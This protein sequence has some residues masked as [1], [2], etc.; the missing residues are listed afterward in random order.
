M[1]ISPRSRLVTA[2]LLVLVGLAA[3]GVG[4]AFA[5]T[6]G[7]ATP[8]GSGVVVV[9]TNLGYQSAAAAGTGIVLRSSGIVLTNNHVIAGATTVKVVVPQTGQSYKADVLGYDKTADVAL[10]RLHGASNLKTISTGDASDLA[11]GDAVTA[12]GNA[13]GTGHLTSVRGRVTGL[14]R[15]ITA[16]DDDGS[17]A[18]RLT[19]LVE[20]DAA[21]QPGDSGGPL[22]DEAG[23]VVGMDTAASSDTGSPFASSTTSDAYAIPIG[24]AL[25]IADQILA[26]K[27]SSTVH[28]GGTAFLGVALESAS[29]DPY[30][31]GGY[32]AE[33]ALVTD[34]VPDGPA[35]SAGLEAGD[36][37]VAIDGHTVTSPAAVGTLLQT[38]KPG[39]TVRVAYVDQ[40]DN[41]T[42][43]SVRLGSGPPQ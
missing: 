5:F 31:Y 15:T 2:L 33:G 10:L 3:V 20:T 9:E 40:Y 41:S 1:R 11:V 32:D 7:K 42:T 37:I 34:V 39:S 13:G 4:A 27:S 23:R 29:S 26:G 6:R 43:A 16:A 21:I 14:D 25:T 18:E 12:V 38:E 22:L 36:V 35:D 8:I 19:G 24:R 17:D 30:D 28:V